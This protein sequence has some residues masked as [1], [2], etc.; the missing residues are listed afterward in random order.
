MEYTTEKVPATITRSTREK[1][2]PNTPLIRG[3]V[4]SDWVL[5]MTPDK[6]NNFK[7][8]TTEGHER[9]GYKI[10]KTKL[11]QVFKG[12]KSC[13]VY[14]W[15]ARH[16]ETQREYVVYVGST[17]RSKGGNF[18]DRIYEYCNNGA[19]KGDFINSALKK[20]YE[21][22]FRYKGSGDNTRTTDP[23]KRRAECDENAA[24]RYFDYAWNIRSVKQIER[25]L[26]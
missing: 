11:R 20:G 10:Q 8:R 12:Q 17:C 21:L 5:A 2:P 24:L 3:W 9:A 1:M 18:V 26:P 16:A 22:W 25:R 13:G 19:H 23:N 4:W 14:E 6:R 7:K 15:K